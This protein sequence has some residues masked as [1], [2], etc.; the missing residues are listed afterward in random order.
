MLQKTPN[1]PYGCD[2]ERD[3]VGWQ[4]RPRL[5]EPQPEILELR[6]AELRGHELVLTNARPTVHAD[7][8]WLSL[9]RRRRLAFRGLFSYLGEIPAVAA[10]FRGEGRC[11]RPAYLVR[12]LAEEHERHLAA[13]LGFGRTVAWFD[14]TPTPSTR[15][16][17]RLGASVP[18]A[19]ARPN[20]MAHRRRVQAGKRRGE[21]R[22][23]V[24]QRGAEARC[25]AVG[26][27]G[28]THP[29]E[30]DW[31][32]PFEISAE[33]YQRMREQPARSR[34][35]DGLALLREE[36]LLPRAHRLARAA[37]VSLSANFDLN[38][39]GNRCDRIIFER[40]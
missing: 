2:A 3:G 22:R 8:F 14:R 1:A 20:P 33:R 40:I 24:G 28:S 6:R 13:H 34:T 19:A 5:A 32:F 26:V 37:S 21:A 16:P 39:L 23:V 29:R 38:V 17:K 7:R 31:C 25:D 9:L 30:Q 11:V 18:E 10:G 27:L 35:G 12:E 36:L 4:R 15:H